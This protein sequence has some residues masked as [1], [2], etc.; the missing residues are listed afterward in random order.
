MPV[1]VSTLESVPLITPVLVFNE[2]PVGSVPA[3]IE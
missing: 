1:F 2:N 3:E